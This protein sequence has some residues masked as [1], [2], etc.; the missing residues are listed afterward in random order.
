VS[1][2]ARILTL[3][4]LVL[5]GGTL[6]GE[7]GASVCPPA[8][9]GPASEHTGGD[10]QELSTVSCC[11]AGG[12][13]LTLTTLAPAPGPGAAQGLGAF[14]L[15]A[16]SPRVAESRRIESVRLAAPLLPSLVLR[17]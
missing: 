4:L 10:C 12:A 6:P 17:I 8:C 16:P 9:C 13:P 3:L 1:R 15:P 2:R 7:A 14:A 11:H 5:L